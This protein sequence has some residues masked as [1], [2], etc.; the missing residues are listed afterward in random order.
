M[1]IDN[2]CQAYLPS[3]G[4]PVVALFRRITLPLQIRIN[5][6]ENWNFDRKKGKLQDTTF[7]ILKKVLL[8]QMET[9]LNFVL[10]AQF[11]ISK[12]TKLKCSSILAWNEIVALKSSP[13]KT[14][15]LM[16]SIYLLK[17]IYSR[18]KQ[19]LPKPSH[20]F[21]L[22]RTTYLT[23]SVSWSRNCAH[24]FQSKYVLRYHKT[25]ETIY[26]GKVLMLVYAL[27]CRAAAF[28]RSSE[29]FL[30][31]FRCDWYRNKRKGCNWEIQI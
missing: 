20:I 31:L 15:Q 26:G 10:L 5:S 2:K 6:T 13:D 17:H 16:L 27:L 21:I 28:Q 25:A 3:A 8:S 22:W 24:P 7:W 12:C 29:I 14:L 4:H 30:M 19:T 18:K 1:E 9:N 11:Y 23:L